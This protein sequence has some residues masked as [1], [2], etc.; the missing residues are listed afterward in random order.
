MNASRVKR[1]ARV[2]VFALAVLVAATLVGLVIACGVERWSVKVGT[3]PDAWQVDPTNPVWTSVSE[4][5]TFPRPSTIPASRRADSVEM[6][7]WVVYATLTQ[8]RRDPDGDYH[9]VLLDDDGSTMI[10]EIPDPNCAAGSAF[11]DYIAN[12]RAQ[13][14]VAFRV[15]TTWHYTSTPVVVTGVGFWN[16]DHGQTGRAVNVIELHPVLDIQF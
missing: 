11:F 7:T 14:D 9:L 1:T 5:N 10:A 16:R 4:M 3:D 13:F 8:Y 12:A 2:V 15:T 6:T